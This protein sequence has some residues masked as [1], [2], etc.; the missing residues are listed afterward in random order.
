[1]KLYSKGQ[2]FFFCF[3]SGLIVVMFALGVGFLRIPFMTKTTETQETAVNSSPDSPK[4]E[5]PGEELFE[6]LRLRQSPYV[7]PLQM[8]TADLV[9]FS[10]GERENIFIY[11]QLNDAVVNITTETVAINWFLEP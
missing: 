3:L 4:G 8:N 11:E 5:D 6:A 10:E 9:P 1:M 7:S 2:L